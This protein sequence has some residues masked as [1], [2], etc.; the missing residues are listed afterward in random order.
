MST[1]LIA[2][3]LAILMGIYAV[4]ALA[5]N[6]QFGVGG[7][8]NFGVA[9]FFGIGAYSYALAVMPAQSGSYTYILGLGLPWW[10]G[11]II[12]GLTAALLA[13]A[14]GL[15]PAE[16][17]RGVPGGGGPGV[18]RGDTSA[19]HQP[20]GDRQWRARPPGRAGAG[21]LTASRDEPSRCMSRHLC[22]WY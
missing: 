8:V 16:G 10:A 12:G 17:Q 14:G 2:G 13:L 21:I 18:G 9:A 1:L 6:L 15:R 3:G 4:A 22:W 19:L 20:A 7:M 11:T 5:L